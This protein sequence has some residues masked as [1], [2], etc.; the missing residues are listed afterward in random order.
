MQVSQGGP[1][2]PG[3]AGQSAVSVVFIGRHHIDSVVT[4]GAHVQGAAVCQVAGVA[5]VTGGRWGLIAPQ[6]G[7]DGEAPTA[8]SIARHLCHREL[9]HDDSGCQGRGTEWARTRRVAL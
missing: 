7:A 3:L 9:R 1:H 4:E 2:L 8:Q 5:A 6:Q